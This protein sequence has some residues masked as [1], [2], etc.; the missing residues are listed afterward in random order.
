MQ[1]PYPP[2]APRSVQ[3]PAR[4]THR[5]VTL[6]DG[7]RVLLRPL[8]PSDR[9]VYLRG[10]EHLG[11]A[12]RYMRF[13]SPKALLTERELHYFLEVDHHDHE[14][15]C[16]TDLATGDGIAVGRFVRDPAEPTVA[17][18]S[19]T[20]VDEHQ[21]R[22]LGA[23]LLEYVALRAAEEGVARLRASVLAD[24]HRMLTL[25]RTRWPRHRVHRGA[26][27]VLELEFDVRR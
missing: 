24:N 13:F 3:A 17:E 18:V 9:E 2:P 12:S 25:I 4:T 23:A 14:A 21:G 22:G 5:L 19:I 10:F 20:V 15:I 11:S 1:L 16:A 27:S 7:G 6:R 26:A 8:R